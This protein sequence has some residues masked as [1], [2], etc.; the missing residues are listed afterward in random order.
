MTV[1]EFGSYS[2]IDIKNRALSLTGPNKDIAKPSS[3]AEDIP[4]VTDIIR[5]FGNEYNPSAAEMKGRKVKLAVASSSSARVQVSHLGRL[6]ILNLF[7]ILVGAV[8]VKAPNEVDYHFPKKSK[9]TDSD[10]KRSKGGL[11]EKFIPGTYSLFL[12]FLGD[13]RKVPRKKTNYRP[14]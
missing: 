11:Y 5:W 12:F 1:G 2:Y 13:M 4:G 10:E 7:D 6:G 9:P 8:G 14:P 3:H